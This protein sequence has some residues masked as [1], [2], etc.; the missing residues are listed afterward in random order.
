VDPETHTK[1]IVVKF[2]DKDA[3]KIQTEI[4]E[5]EA[6]DPRHSIN[7]K[8]M[9]PEERKKRIWQGRLA[10][11][12]FHTWLKKNITIPRD[13]WQADHVNTFDKHD[14]WL[15]NARG[16]TVL[17]INVK[18]AYFDPKAGISAVDL[19]V[20]QEQFHRENTDL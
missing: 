18:S 12:T 8:R 10:E 4:D 16:E 5:R 19:N 14:F 9:T 2:D 1:M 15:K 3:E 11:V 7:F 13:C 17:R 20:N 6:K